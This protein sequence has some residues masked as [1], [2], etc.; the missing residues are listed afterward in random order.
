LGI[1]RG[2]IHLGISR[3]WR[4]WYYD[5]LEANSAIL[6]KFG[7][8]H[9]K[10]QLRCIYPLFLSLELVRSGDFA[11]I[12]S[13]STGKSPGTVFKVRVTWAG[14]AWDGICTVVNILLAHVLYECYEYRFDFEQVLSGL[15]SSG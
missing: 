13:Q 8:L 7:V 15:I 6:K 14:N 10:Y 3:S 12:I 2:T 11:N 9:G 4:D 1:C 5:C